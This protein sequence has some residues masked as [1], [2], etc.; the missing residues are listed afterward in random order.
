MLENCGAT[1]GQPCD[2]AFG[3]RIFFRI[4]DFELIR[5]GALSKKSSPSKGRA[6]V[7][8]HSCRVELDPLNMYCYMWNLS[9]CFRLPV[10]ACRPPTEPI[11]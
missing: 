6:E 4:S 10:K 8:P 9:V 2:S 11:P 7:N 1:P 5:I 3:L